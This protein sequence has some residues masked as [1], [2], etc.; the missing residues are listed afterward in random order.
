VA[1]AGGNRSL[2][3]VVADDGRGID[4]SDAAR[5]MSA[6]RL[7]L[8]DMAQRGRVGWCVAGDRATV[9]AWYGRHYEVAWVIR[10][11]VVDDHPVAAAG[12]IAALAEAGGHR[13]RRSGQNTRRGEAG[14]RCRAPGCDPVRHPA[15]DRAGTGPAESAGLACPAGHL[16]HVVRL[17]VVRS[18]RTGPPARGV[19]GESG[20][21][22]PRSWRP[23]DRWRRG[24]R[25]M[26][27]LI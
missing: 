8:A 26:T 18:G 19:R 25:P 20:R 6:G 24:A 3:L 16:L 13:D 21:R 5:A 10:V 11:M 17:S 23:S 15:G 7:G 1:I 12:V 22:W 9:T 14:R 2:E 4:R 27:R